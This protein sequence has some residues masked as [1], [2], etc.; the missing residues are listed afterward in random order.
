[1]VVA[2][3]PAVVIGHHGHGRVA[4]LRLTRQLG[5]LQ[6]RHADH[7]R[8]PASVEIRLG[9]RRELRTFH[10]YIGPAWFANQAFHLAGGTNGPR[11][12]RA[13]R[14]SKRHMAYNAIS[15]KGR[16]AMERTINELIG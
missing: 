4:N 12:N 5:L 16:D 7:V 10:A 1:G 15:K 14:I 9:A 3:V 13:H 11:H 2:L 6:V 8:A